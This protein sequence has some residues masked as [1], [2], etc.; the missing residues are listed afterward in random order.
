MSIE[1]SFI[2]KIISILD[3]YQEWGVQPTF[4]TNNSYVSPYR[5]STKLEVEIYTINNE[6]EDD[7]LDEI[8]DEIFDEIQGISN[9]YA[10]YNDIP[11]YWESW[12]EKIKKMIKKFS[13]SK[14]YKEYK[15]KYRGSIAAKNLGLL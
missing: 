9:N 12:V 8:L 1:D 11:T 7:S 5:N 10:E 4:S 2:S 13:K 6:L 14:I 3:N 15:E